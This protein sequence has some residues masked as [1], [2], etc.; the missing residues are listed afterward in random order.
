MADIKQVT[1][2][3]NQLGPAV[4][5]QIH[6][7]GEK[8]P[9]TYAYHSIRNIPSNV[10][11]IGYCCEPKGIAYPI[12]LLSQGESDWKEY[13]IGKTGM[14]EVQPEEWK[15]VNSENEEDREGLTAY[16][17]IIGIKVPDRIKFVLDYV[18]F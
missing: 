9:I 3:S 16:T 15:D 18:N 11:K 12:F 1:N 2:Y 13:Q 17:Y 7:K 8:D 10:A 4:N 6:K 5:E 14:L